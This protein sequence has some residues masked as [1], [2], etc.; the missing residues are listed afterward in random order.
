MGHIGIITEYNP[1]HNGHKH[2]I[3]T[4]KQTFPGK[5]IIILMSGDFVQRGT[6]ALFNKYIRT[7]CALAAGADIV[8][9]LPPLFATASAEHFASAGVLAFAK[10]SVVDTLCFGAETD[11]VNALNKIAAMLV[12]EPAAYKDLLK[13]ELKSGLS[14][15]KARMQAVAKYF[16]N[17]KYNEILKYPNNILGIEYMKAIIKYNLNITPHIIKRKDHGYHDLT[18]DNTLCSASALRNLFKNAK[19]DN[20][21]YSQ[22]KA[23][24][25]ENCYSII[26]SAKEAR[27]LYASD[28]YS[29]LQ[30][31]LITNKG[32]YEQYLDFPK[33]LSNQLKAM[34]FLPAS[35]EEL[36]ALLARK[37][38]TNT[39]IS[40]TLFNLLLNNL[41]EEMDFAKQHTYISYLRLLG[42]KRAS[43]SIIKKIQQQ[44]II[45]IINKV[46]DAK[47]KLPES[48]LL[49]FEKDLNTSNLYKQS[50]MNKYGISLP[51]EHEQSVIILDS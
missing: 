24:M 30:Y 41:Q 48:A 1:F 6:P 15:P 35:I 50:F 47:A 38:Y 34:T 40:R 27:P 46:A 49:R 8:F 7:K 4:I 5:N 39:R 12:E 51:S 43:T 37:N 16:Q 45:P 26:K 33:E 13:A 42:A 2:Q 31:A 11:D 18:V 28:F 23:Q 29:Y 25:P 17:E 3:N 44:N 14:F 9:E 32:N 21:L 20:L 36:F 22:I 19:D 10:T